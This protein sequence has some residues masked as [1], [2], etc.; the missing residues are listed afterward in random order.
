MHERNGEM[1]NDWNGMT[2]RAARALCRIG[3]WGNRWDLG[4]GSAGIAYRQSNGVLRFLPKCLS[5]DLRIYF[6]LF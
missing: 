5:R 1:G 2:G 6:L 3:P 4:F